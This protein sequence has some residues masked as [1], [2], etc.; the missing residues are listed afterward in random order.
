LEINTQLTDNP[1][2]IKYEN[3]ETEE[4]NQIKRFKRAIQ[5]EPVI[6]VSTFDLTIQKENLSVA[7]SDTNRNSHL[8]IQLSYPNEIFYFENQEVKS[9]EEMSTFQ[10]YSELIWLIKK[11]TKKA[12][13]LRNG[14]VSNPN[15]WISERIIDEINN[16]INLKTN[17]I[18]LT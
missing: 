4:D 17:F 12:K 6:N 8:G 2:Y 14:K 5:I 11:I 13:A 16:N 1:C 15:F 10:L 7:Y 9:T 3:F 18:K